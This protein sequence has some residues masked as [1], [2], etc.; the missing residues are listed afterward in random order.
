MLR[1]IE[2]VCV[3]GVVVLVGCTGE[4]TGGE[5]AA[6][7]ASGLTLV[8]TDDGLVLNGSPIDPRYRAVYPNPDRLGRM[9]VRILDGAEVEVTCDTECGESPFF[10]ELESLP[11]GLTRVRLWDLYG[12]LVAEEDV[13]SAE[14]ALRSTP[15]GEGDY[16][17]ADLPDTGDGSGGDLPDGSSEC[18]RP[19]QK[20]RFCDGVNSELAARGLSAYAIDCA[21][22]GDSFDFRFP[23]GDFDVEDPPLDRCRDV[24]D[25][26]A[27]ELEGEFETADDWCGELQL[28]AWTENTRM[29]LIGG[30][31]CDSSPIVLDLDDDGVR[32]GHVDEG[33]MFDLLGDGRLVQTAWPS[34]GD[35][36]LAL[37]RNRNGRIDGATELF[38]NFTAGKRYDDGFRALAVLDENGDDRIDARDRAFTQLAL[39]RDASQDGV[40]D[41]SELTTLTQSGVRALGLAPRTVRGL[42]SVDP[43]GNRIPLVSWFEREDGTRGT[44]V[45]AWLRYRPGPQMC[46]PVA[47]R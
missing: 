21:D 20:V 12:A 4:V 42:A 44:L 29:R 35:A 45:D 19:E 39:W 30:G 3:F 18:P 40:S 25:P 16:V 9:E 43:N 27:D 38:G 26:I 24:L 10:P 33:A 14:M 31:V 28:E 36:F 6:G 17:P 13:Q 22:I 34:A 47:M 11:G 41:L 37:D 5:S 1:R 7:S 15:D 2:L 46:D 23:R 8:A 32:I